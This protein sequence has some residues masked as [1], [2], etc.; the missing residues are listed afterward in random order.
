MFDAEALSLL[1]CPMCGAGDLRHKVFDGDIVEAVVWCDGCR[2]WYPLEDGVLDLLTGDLAYREDRPRFLARHQADIRALDL[3]ED[4]RVDSG[5]QELQT[6]QQS[7]FDWYAANEKQ[8]YL[9][10]EQMPFWRAAD[11]IAFAD[12]RTRIRPGSW[13]L[14]IGCG[15]GRST[16]KLTDLDIN[17]MAFDVSKGAIRQAEQRARAAKQAARTRFFL[18]DA[19]RLPLKASVMDY[20]LVYGVLHHVP[21]PRATCRELARVLKPGGVYFGSENNETVFRRAFDW[22]QK[23]WPI[24]YEEAGPEALISATTM[25]EAFSSTGVSI[26]TRSSVF[27]PPHLINLLPNGLGK[28]LL[29]LGDRV[30]RALPG[31]D[32][33]GGLILIEGVKSTPP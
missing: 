30:G 22:L 13:L 11:D 27:L 10:Y 26:R 25:N 20:V 29:K 15:N 18:A 24:W 33:N 21:D 6:K 16:F 23:V 19:M 17:I 12:W 7:H 14:D 2:N 8:S 5:Q 4:A 9:E 31:L 1:A 3:R 32:R 28:S